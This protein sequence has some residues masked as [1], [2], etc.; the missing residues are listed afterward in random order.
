[1]RVLIAALFTVGMVGVAELEVAWLSSLGR[2]QYTVRDVPEV[3][4]ATIR[5]HGLNEPRVTVMDLNKT[6]AQQEK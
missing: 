1:M 3:S 4:Q 5:S 6:S 2:R